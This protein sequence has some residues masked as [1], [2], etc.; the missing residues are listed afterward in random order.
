MVTYFKFLNSNPVAS[1]S[2][3]QGSVSC[4]KLWQTLGS[5]QEI[6]GKISAEIQP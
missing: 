6:G 5:E 2:V 3:C 4:G 1:E